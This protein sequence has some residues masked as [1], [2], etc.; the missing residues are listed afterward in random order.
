VVHLIGGRTVM[1]FRGSNGVSHKVKKKRS[2]W[3]DEYKKQRSLDAKN[4][5]LR[6]YKYVY[7]SGH[8]RIEKENKFQGASC[9]ACL[10]E[11][12]NNFFKFVGR[13]TL[14]RS[15]AKKSRF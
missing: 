4:P 8:I 12:K 1:G 5:D 2:N 6:A 14:P 7:P 11:G 3:K 9:Q 13:Y 10:S 15:E